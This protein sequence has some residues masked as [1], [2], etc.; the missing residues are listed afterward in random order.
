MARVKGVAGLFLTA[1]CLTALAGVSVGEDS[2]QW[3]DAI[4]EVKVESSFDGTQQPA[5]FY[6]PST[7]DS[8]PLLVGLHTWSGNYRQSMSIPYAE[9]CIEKNWVFIHPNFRGPNKTPEATGSEAAVQDIVDAVEYAKSHAKVD[10]SRIYLVGVSGGGYSSILLAGR[11]PD[12]WAGV[13][14]WVPLSDVKEWY[15]DCVE[16]GERYAGDVLASVG[17]D[18]TQDPA[19]AEECRKR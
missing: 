19:A 17:G 8:R 6:S 10:E 4:S 11:H 16:S 12:I 5:L 9:W 7:E 18:P 14:A 1:W 3:P 13:S 2:P 15:I